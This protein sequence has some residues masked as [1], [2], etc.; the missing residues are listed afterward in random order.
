M[1]SCFFFDV[2]KEKAYHSACPDHRKGNNGGENV[3]QKP[4]VNRGKKKAVKEVKLKE[5]STVVVTRDWGIVV[6]DHVLTP[7]SLTVLPFLSLQFL[8]SSTPLSLPFLC[9]PIW[10]IL[11]FKITLSFCAHEGV[12]VLK[13]RRLLL[14]LDTRCLWGEGSNNNNDRG[15][16]VISVMDGAIQLG[17]SLSGSHVAIQAANRLL[18]E[19]SNEA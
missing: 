3:S 12:H 4:K 14:A 6:S 16:P 18:M 10:I 17:I 2:Q 7:I 1:P 19:M 13:K 5:K 15:P 8:I 11:W 9:L